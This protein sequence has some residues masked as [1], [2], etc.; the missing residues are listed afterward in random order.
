[1][2]VPLK[3]IEDMGPDEAQEAL[4][5]TREIRDAVV[6]HMPNRSS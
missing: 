6:A 3:H 1:M 4:E 2:S 5:A